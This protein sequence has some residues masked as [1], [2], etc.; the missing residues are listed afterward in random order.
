MV[1]VVGGGPSGLAA[2][3]THLL[4][5]Y[6]VTLYEDRGFA[7]KPCGEAVFGE[8]ARYT[9]FSNFGGQPFIVDSFQTIKLCFDDAPLR[10]LDTGRRI[11][12]LDKRLFL[13]SYWEVCRSM[14]GVLVRGHV[15][16]DTLRSKGS[17]VIDAT[18]FRSRNKG[19]LIPVV[20]AYA[21]PRGVRPIN[22]GEALLDF[23]GKGYFW[24]FPYGDLYNV[25]FGGHYD[26]SEV[27]DT[28]TWHLK[29]YG[30]EVKGRVDGAAINV[31]PPRVD[32]YRVGE[33]GGWVNALTG[34]GIRF[35]LMSGWGTG[36]P[37]DLNRVARC[38]GRAVR[39]EGLATSGNIDVKG[40]LRGLG[41]DRFAALFD[42]P[43]L[44]DVIRVRLPWFW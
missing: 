19:T 37:L 24:I 1:I 42:C 29:R 33:A 8:V 17:E 41:S 38:L 2:A 35:A 3:Y 26:G 44:F 20:R 14:G 18:G 30:L 34:E 43:T 9:P 25:G 40:I 28:L 7:S 16:P 32:G 6:G 4:K 12:I 22:H 21:K 10:Y 39:L 27:K 23:H 11:L 15:D 13:E 5:G 36:I 31:L